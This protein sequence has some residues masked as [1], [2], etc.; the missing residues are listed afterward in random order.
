MGKAHV[1]T[2]A[3]T[4][5][6]ESLATAAGHLPN[7][8]EQGNTKKSG[9][10]EK[11]EPKLPKNRFP[12]LSTISKHRGPVAGPPPL[13]APTGT[14]DAK[15]SLA[16]AAGDLRDKLEGSGNKTPEKSSAVGPSKT[17][18]PISRSQSGIV[19][20]RGPG[21][22]KASR[23][24]PTESVK[25]ANDNEEDKAKEDDSGED[26]DASEDNDPGEDEDDDATPPRH[27]FRP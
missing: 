11:H 19:K 20:R 9:T 24:A 23:K 26:D 21:N 25:F 16:A 15:N 6:K 2:A 5:I 10:G 3:K 1:T 22:G 4:D 18:T 14:A 8:L 7:Q 17:R 12:T 27:L 13:K